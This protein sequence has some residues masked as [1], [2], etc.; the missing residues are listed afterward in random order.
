M[1]SKT[2]SNKQLFLNNI[3]KYS[4]D[5]ETVSYFFDQLIDIAELNNLSEEE[6][7]I[8]L[9]SNLNGAAL[10]F[11][12]TSPSL[13]NEKSLIKI[14]EEFIKFFSDEDS[15]AQKH[16]LFNTISYSSNEPIKSLAHRIRSAAEE[17]NDETNSF[18]NNSLLDNIKKVKL[19]SVLPEKFRKKL[20]E[21]D[22]K[23][24]N[25]AVEY[26]V[27]IESNI[28]TLNSIQ[29]NNMLLTSNDSNNHAECMNQLSELK[30]QINMLKTESS[31][32]EE[33]KHQR[34]E[35][36]NSQNLMCL[37]CGKTNHLII[38]CYHF[39]KF[40]NVSTHQFNNNRS[41]HSFRRNT[42][43][44]GRNHPY[45]NEYN[46]NR[47]QFNTGR[48]RPNGNNRFRNNRSPNFR[49]RNSQNTNINQEN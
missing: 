45:R 32:S 22:P 31:K 37:F 19:Y 44:P 18:E 36:Y 25:E 17:L 34:K 4:G 7:I 20:I 40:Q 21:K 14:K 46:S 26:A 29:L 38:N 28:N 2:K 12:L 27:K 49:Q 10:K 39:L 23:T 47:N 43:R 24:F 6:K 48:Y 42:R 11:Y 15:L 3:P 1:A 16:L 8:L 41:T 9:K 33:N 35:N 13:R 5:K 30:E